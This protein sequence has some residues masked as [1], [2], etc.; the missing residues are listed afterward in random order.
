M[1][2]EISVLQTVAFSPRSAGIN[3]VWSAD[4]QKNKKIAKSVLVLLIKVNG[5][6]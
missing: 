6:I 5:D 1:L 2:E 4:Y 3:F